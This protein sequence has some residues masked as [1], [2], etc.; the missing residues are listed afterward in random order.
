MKKKTRNSERKNDKQPNTE[1]ERE[2]IHS[3]GFVYTSV[4][5]AAYTEQWKNKDT[6]KD[7]STYW[8]KNPTKSP[9]PKQLAAEH[10]IMRKKRNAK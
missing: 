9:W 4:E 7:F 6:I 2:S 10:K 1:R 8:P 5:V 3:Q